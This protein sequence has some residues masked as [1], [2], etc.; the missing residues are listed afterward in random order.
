VEIKIGVQD[1]AR[2]LTVETT[3]TA[4]EVEAQLT[5]ALTDGGLLTLTDEKGRKVLIPAAKVAY[6]DLGQEKA[7]PV[8]F[9]A[10]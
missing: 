8:G 4:A 5:K 9:G 1:I 2:E 10:L 7:R 3:A 6:V